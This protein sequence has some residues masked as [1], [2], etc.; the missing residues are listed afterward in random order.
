M[1]VVPDME[2]LDEEEMLMMA[3]A[4]SLQEETVEEE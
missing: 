1:K 2:E 4:M 3:I